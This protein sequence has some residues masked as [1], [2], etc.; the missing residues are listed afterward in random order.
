[1]QAPVF[2]L[3]TNTKRES[4]RRAQLGNIAA[5]KAV[6]D[7]IRTTLGPRS[8]LKM[9]LDPMGGI[10]LTNDG[11]AILREVDVAHPAAKSMIEMARAQDEEVGDGTTSVIVLAG[12]ILA[13][14]EPFLV[15][16][17]HPTVIV[18][19]YY[20]A[21]DVA[22]ETL[23][24]MATRVD[25]GG[26][27]IVTSTLGTKFSGRWG[28]LL[29]DM[30]LDAVNKITIEQAD[31]SKEIDI[32]RYARV[33]KIPGEDISACRVLDGVMINKD[34]TH[35]SMP[36]R[37]EKPRILLLDCTLEYKKGESQTSVELTK[38]EDWARMLELEEEHIKELCG[39]LLRLEPDIVCTEKGISDLAQ[40]YFV[41]KGVAA[42][43]RLRKTDMNRLARAC[44]ATICHRPD[45]V[46][47]EDIG[48][49]CSLFE[50]NKIGDEYFSNFI[51]CE[52]PKACTLLLRGGSKDVLMEVERNLQDALQAARNVALD[53][54]LLPGG[55]A[56]ELEVGAA[57]RASADSIVGPG[58]WSY[59]AVADALEVVPRTLLENAGVD[60]VRKI[61]ELRALHAGGDKPASG[62]DGETGEIVDTA[63]A[64]I[65][66]TMRVKK[67]TLR[68]AIEAA[69]LMLRI[70]DV[71][72]G[73]RKS[74]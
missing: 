33:E 10:V 73:T 8:M 55:G 50:V 47:E 39:H 69:C 64:G 28:P 29:V 41:T 14:A 23:K 24:K 49:G 59:L 67:Q 3:N 27:A 20:K 32:K 74:S 5:T 21:M 4:G 44:G 12:E 57:I 66:D 9:L 35:A 13:L 62:V 7:I 71:V 43:R 51:G 34:I 70:D 2:V 46:T 68:T 58:R 22:M 15:R 6:A 63:A 30:A 31:G 54:E 38:E 36:R 60:V 1:M 56:V 37:I 19:S 17:I 65:W 72:S 42:L 26:R 61:T 16:E 53:P 45:E 48:T 11:H 25:D 52:D 40:H 18:R